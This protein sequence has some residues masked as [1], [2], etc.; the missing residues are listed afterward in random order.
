MNPPDFIPVLPESA[1]FTAE[2]RAYLNGFLAGLLSRAPMPAATTAA[3]EEK[4]LTPL[5]ILF[6]SQTG[7]AE[8][9][10]RRLAKEAGKRGFAATIHDLAK[11]PVAQLAAEKALLVITST[12]GDGEPPDNARAFAEFIAAAAAPGLA[13]VRF[14]ICAL[15]DMNYP[16]FCAFGKALDER[17][18]KLGATRVHARAEC[19]ADFEEAFVRWMP[20]ALAGF[21]GEVIRKAVISET[22]I[23]KQDTTRPSPTHGTPAT[24]SLITDSLITAPSPQPVRHSK[25]NPFPAPLL[26][27]R[28][29]NAPGSGKDVRHFEIGLHGSGLAYEAGDALAVMPRNDPTLVGEILAA[30]GCSGEETV[31]GRGGEPLPMR[32]ALTAHYEITRIPKPLVEL[33]AVRTGEE[34]LQRVSS[35]TANGELTKFLH[36]REIIDLLLA[37]PG[38]RLAAAEFIAL[39]RKLPPR[40]YSISSSPKAHPGEVHLTVGTV[41]YES[42]GRTRHGVCSTFLADRVTPETR[43]PVFVHT[44]KA[45]RP[46]APDM[47]LIMV[48]PG[49][50][51]APFRAFLEERRA[52]GATGKNWLFFGDQKSDTDFL[53][54]EE[55]ESCRKDGL[56]TRLDL[57]WSRDQGDKVYVQHRMLEHAR[58]L[59]AWLEAG[60][61][62]CV[63][64]DAS[65]MA[66]DVDAALHQVIQTAGGKSP[67]EATATVTALK[68]DKRY[69]RDVY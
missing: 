61:S 19:D 65:R 40:L 28:R 46:P 9:L 11:Y 3:P 5:T 30:L 50:G 1:P 54:R 25:Q 36:G 13:G 41:R 59:Y 57:A 17:F 22:V 44:N 29:L 66:R 49:T 55:I 35:P 8:N 42:L 69:V 7:N 18:E 52:T 23:S 43:V 14:S 67:E 15:G 20:A 27:N 64:G 6:G 53:Y 2:Q 31:A 48:G 39:L 12:Y 47:P 4:P 10:A 60:A 26:T 34:M 45:F 51:I 58:E 24:V 62:F 33:F 16:K 63:C 37:H 68:R 56:L 38:V 21:G 32:E